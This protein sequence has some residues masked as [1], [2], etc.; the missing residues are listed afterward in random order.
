M[1]EKKDR[2]VQAAKELIVTYGFKKTTMNEIAAKARMAKSTMYYYFKNKEDI[3]AEIVRID[4]EL[5]R[6]KLQDAISKA[7]SPQDKIMQY[8]RTRMLHLKE[9]SNYYK[10]LTN[11]YLDHYFF[12][13]QVRED[14]YNFESNVLSNLIN[15][16]ISQSAFTPCKVDVVVRMIAIAI[17][18]LEYPLFVQK[19]QDL[20]R[21]SKQMMEIIFKG[22]EVRN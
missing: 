21:D 20:E 8:V 17:K 2:I 6:I 10:T 15:E 12:I 3:F 1:D 18:G 4:S 11:E 16:G 7:Y 13:E 5:F 9:L 14:F 19:S 22:I